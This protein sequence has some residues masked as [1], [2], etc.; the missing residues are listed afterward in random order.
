M[1]T[2]LKHEEA[3]IRAFVRPE[4]RARLIEQLGNPKGRAK[5][6]ASLAHFRDLD[7]R[8]AHRVPGSKHNAGD[9]EALLRS[10]GAPEACHVVSELAD[11]DGRD[12]LLA[13]ALEAIVGSGMGAFISCIPGV[14]G[15]FESEEVHDRYILER[16]V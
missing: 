4:K 16:T 3:L 11:L 15:Y 8:F 9:I 13:T 1:A 5:L 10:K 14:L 6:C 7:L 2:V 12:M